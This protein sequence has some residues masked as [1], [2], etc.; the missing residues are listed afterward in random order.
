M[1]IRCNPSYSIPGLSLP[2]V[3]LV[4][5]PISQYADDT[6]FILSTDDSVKPVLDSYFLFEKAA[7]SWL[8]HSKSKGLSLGTWVSRVD[9]P[10][11]LN[12]SPTKLTILGVLCRSVVANFSSKLAYQFL[13]A[14]NYVGS[15]YVVKFGLLLAHF[16]GRPLGIN[17]IMI[18]LIVPVLQAKIF[19]KSRFGNLLF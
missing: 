12:W 5:S 7:G 8:N 19:C 15:Y 6:T 1:N 2:R 11:A 10:V 17:F 14:E 3:S 9:P 4:V 16:I 18:I 13:P